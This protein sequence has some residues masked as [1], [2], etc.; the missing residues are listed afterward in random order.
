M[1]IKP[2]R[3]PAGGAGA[4]GNQGQTSRGNQKSHPAQSPSETSAHTP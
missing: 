4:I 2:T 3:L 1:I